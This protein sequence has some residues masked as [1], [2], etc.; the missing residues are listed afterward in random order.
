M[1]RSRHPTPEEVSQLLRNAELRDE[2]EP[3][4][5]ESI[6]LVNVRD[7][8]VAVENEFLASMLAWEMAPVLPIYRWFDPELRP[9]RPETLNDHDLHEILWDVIYK[10]YE[11]RIVLDFTDHL[12]D[13]ELYCLIYRDILPAREKKIDNRKTYL[14]WDCAQAGGDPEVWLRY[15]ASE[16]ERRAWAETYR[17]PLP[18]QGMPPHKRRLPTEPE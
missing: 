5:D 14:H 16:E 7:L 12:S 17:Q 15:Y 6:S 10:L 3:F 9:P 11:K 4:Y 18:P 2:L 8:P 1:A 13:R